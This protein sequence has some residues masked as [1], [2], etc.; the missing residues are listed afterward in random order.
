V[1]EGEAMKSA[2]QM[3]K[4]FI[5]QNKHSSM[6]IEEDSIADEEERKENRKIRQSISSFVSAQ[7]ANQDDIENRERLD[8]QK[9]DITM[10]NNEDSELPDP[11]SKTASMISDTLQMSMSS[12][13]GEELQKFHQK[14]TQQN[15]QSS[16]NMRSGKTNQPLENHCGI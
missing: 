15:M 12:A 3:R 9:M 6:S 1:L 7:F 5:N 2:V 14:V 4:T 16:N 10:G 11:F 8:V 13:Q